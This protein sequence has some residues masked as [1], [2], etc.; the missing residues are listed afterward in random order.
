MRL[1]RF[2][3]LAL[4]LALLWTAT[5]ARLPAQEAK[6]AAVSNH[7]GNAAVQYWQAFSFMPNLDKEQEKLL[8]D[9]T[10][11]DEW[12]KVPLHPEAQKLVDASQAS[13]MYL[14]RGAKLALCDWGLEYDDGIRLLLPHLAKARD[15]VRLAAL[16]ARIALER[17]DYQAARADA[18]A[19][20]ALARH[21]GSDPI[22][23]SILVGIGLENVGIELIAPYVP[24]LKMPHAQATA[25]F[26]ALPRAAK[27]RDS[28]LLEKEH[29]ARWVIRK[30][31]EEEA[32]KPGAGLVLWHNFL[33]GSE[34]PEAVKQIKSVDE[35]IRLTERLLPVYDDLARFVVL[36]NDQFDAQYPAFKKKTKDENPIAGTLL[37][38]IDL[39]RAKEQRG[40][41]RLAMLLASFA[42]VES[43]PEKLKEI[44]DPFGDGP[45][46]YKALD[47]GFELKSKLLFEGQPV[48][49][50]V[51]Q[52]KK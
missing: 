51:G 22:M 9:I 38:A 11:V 41:A 12:H 14:R 31:M 30:L 44:K 46:E 42:V 16:R 39:I 34:I 40:E 27:L 24:D 49:L 7:N 29:M 20:M 13:L 2:F 37:P 10:K 32:R 33:E 52:R 43:G 26:A 6:P 50:V 3:V 23:I 21:V 36:P 19:I 15:L 1:P 48:T 5:A 28:I 25:A 45:F 18:T 17:G 47:Q 8:Q 35:T 4:T